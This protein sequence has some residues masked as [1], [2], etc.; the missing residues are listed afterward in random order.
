MKNISF[1]TWMTHY[2][3]DRFSLH[4]EVYV[5]IIVISIEKIIA[6]IYVC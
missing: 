5:I 4:N 2:D 3:V 1:G 6:N